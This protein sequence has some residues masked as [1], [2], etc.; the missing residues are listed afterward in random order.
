MGMCSVS[1][2][3]KKKNSMGFL[4]KIRIVLLYNLEILFVFIYPQDTKCL[5]P[6]KYALYYLLQLIAQWLRSGINLDT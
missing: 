5:I 1:V 4:S 2:S 6:K 3:I